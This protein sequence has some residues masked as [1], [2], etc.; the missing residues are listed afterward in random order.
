MTLETE[1]LQVMNFNHPYYKLGH[2]EFTTLTTMEKNHLECKVYE[3]KSS[4]GDRLLQIVSESGMITTFLNDQIP[5]S[6][7]GLEVE[8]IGEDDGKVLILL[9]PEVGL[10]IITVN[11]MNLAA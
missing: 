1:D 3:G 9:P 2:K 8:V 4:N 7:K 11:V 5:F 10:E 6:E